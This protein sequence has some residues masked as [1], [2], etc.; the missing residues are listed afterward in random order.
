MSALV[1]L[2]RLSVAYGEQTVV[3]EVSLEIAPG[4]IVAVVG[5][6]GSG[7]S[8][9]ANAVLGLLPASGRILGGSIE[10]AGGDVTRASEMELRR[11][12]GRVV[13]LVPQDPMVGLDPTLRIGAQ[14]AEAVRLRGVD[15]RAVDAE[16]L[17]ALGQAG[18]DDPQLRARQYPHELSGGLRQRAL[19]AIALAGKPRLIIADEPTSALDVT[20]QKRIL[21][22]LQSLV[23][24]QGIALLIITHDLAVAADRADRVL[25]MRGGRVIE[26]GPP[27]EIL[28]APREEYTRAL[29]DAAPG[30]GHGGAIVPRFDQVEPAPEIL[31]IEKVVKDFA[32]PGRR[33]DFRALDDVSFS[34]RAGQTLAL[35]GESGSGKTTALRIAL[36]LERASGGRVLVEGADLTHAGEKQWRPLRRRI[37]LVHQNPFAALDPRFTVLESVVEPLVSFGVGDRLTRLA[38]AHE[39]LDR[40]GLPDS[41]L[42]RLPAEL[43]GGQRQRVAIARALALGPDLVLLDEPVSA[44]DV[45][46]QAQILELLVELQ[47]DLGVAY[48]FISHDLAVVADVSH[49]IVVLNRG[50]VEEAG[51]TSR[52]FRSPESE[53]TRT[54]LAAIPGVSAV[55]S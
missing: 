23:R 18:I 39:L 55:T 53:Y 54:L 2:D 25:V 31:R 37:Q 50:R 10:I 51:T 48:L 28:V 46:V 34:V 40:V 44:L 38:R 17:E 15:R 21:D 9:T 5:E 36:G 19:I 49:D 14:V 16:V 26:Q 43:S 22:H 42:S 32:L 47:R 4:E 1:R 7:K 52:V 3:H 29:I 45:S 41:F 20:V 30:L 24:E 11:L 8:T 6:S 12:R 33:A 27:A 35:V 13:G